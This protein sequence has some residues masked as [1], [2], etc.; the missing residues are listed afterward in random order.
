[1]EFI[2][3]IKLMVAII[4]TAGDEFYRLLVIFAVW[5]NLRLLIIFANSL[6]PM[7]RIK[8]ITKYTAKYSRNTACFAINPFSQ[9]K[10][11]V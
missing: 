10:T 11:E 7:T 9:V 6:D 1:M 8:S 4:G 5:T 2:S 3:V